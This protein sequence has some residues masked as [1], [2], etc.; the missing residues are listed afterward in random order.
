MPAVALR[1]RRQCYKRGVTRGTLTFGS[2][3]ATTINLL[4]HLVITTRTCNKPELFEYY[5]I[6]TTAISARFQVKQ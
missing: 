6:E 4:F 2:V 5:T 3:L 1:D